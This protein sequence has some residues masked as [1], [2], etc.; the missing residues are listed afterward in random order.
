MLFRS[1]P[2]IE[3]INNNTVCAFADNQI[4]LFRMK[5]IPEIISI[6][7]IEEKIHAVF[8]SESY[9][10]LITES[11]K[12]G[13]LFQLQVFT[14]DGKVVDSISEKTLSERYTNAFFT[15]D[16]LVLYNEYSCEIINMDGVEKFNYTFERNIVLLKYIADSRYTLITPSSISEIRLK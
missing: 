7:P 14:A 16:S 12:E 8:F 4:V 1:V 5:E 3:F 13:A 2:K 9:I 6:I 10:G 15:N 11:K